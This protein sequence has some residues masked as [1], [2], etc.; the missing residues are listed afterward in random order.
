MIRYKLSD[1]LVFQLANLF[2]DR[3]IHVGVKS[4]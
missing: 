2:I 1:I 3:V 4:V